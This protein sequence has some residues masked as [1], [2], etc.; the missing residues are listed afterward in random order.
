M[1]QINYRCRLGHCLYPKGTFGFSYD[2]I[3]GIGLLLHLLILQYIYIS[4]SFIYMH[5]ILSQYD[6]KLTII[7]RHIYYCIGNFGSN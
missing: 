2:C 6:P 1:S 4:L 3:Q 7:V 5:I